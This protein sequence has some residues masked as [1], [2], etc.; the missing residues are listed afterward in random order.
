M[1]LKPSCGVSTGVRAA[2]LIVPYGI[3]TCSAAAA[4][5]ALLI[6]PYGIE[7][8]LYNNIVYAYLLLIV[9]YGIETL[10]NRTG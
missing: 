8:T 4:V 1:E 2:L 7:T 6:V 10:C 9:P 5:A 3:E